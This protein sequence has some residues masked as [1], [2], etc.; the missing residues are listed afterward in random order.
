MSLSTVLL[1]GGGGFIG[2]HVAHLLAERNIR[3]RVPTR[4]RDRAK[5]LILLPTVDVIEADVHDP[6]ALD[7]LMQGVDAVVN[8]A[9]ILHA[10]PGNPWGADFER[11]HVAL[12][13]AVS[14]AARAAGVRRMV[15]VSAL[16]AA[17][18]AP[19]AYQ[20]S[21]AAGEAAVRDSGLDWT[22]VRPSLVFGDGECFLRLFAGVLKL[23]P[24]LPLAGAD[25]RFQ[26]VD[27]RDVARC[28]V[29]ALDCEAAIGQVY[30]LCG[31][32]VYTMRELAVLTGRTIGRNPCI[33]GL[34]GPLATLQAL[35][36][37]WAPGRTLMSRDNLL[38]MRVD[39]VCAAGC[40]LP[41]GFAP[42][43]LE[44]E[45]KR[46]LADFTPTD[47]FEHARSKAHR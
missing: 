7:N 27:V 43:A 19:S 20:R 25:V 28:I 22:I 44:S 26:P 4:R 33:I 23:S 34:P 46:C 12:P 38:S 10:R 35:M 18:D 39:N 15:Q 32:K 42:T 37:E 6:A 17:S 13:R 9:G 16:G 1:I 3:V 24:I 40:T 11:V 2:S 36:L 41:F 14:A 8:L 47:R 21:K 30:P 5:H 45:I 29:H 31:P